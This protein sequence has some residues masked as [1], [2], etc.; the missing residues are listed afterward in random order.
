MRR[1]LLGVFFVLAVAVFLAAGA[2]NSSA[3]II[4]NGTLSTADGNLVS[5]DNL[6]VPSTVDWSIDRTDGTFTYEYTFN[7]DSSRAL[8]H[9]DIE[10]SSNFT[11]DDILPGTTSYESLGYDPHAGPDLY[12][13]KFNGS[14]TS[15]TATIVTHRMPMWGDIYLK[16]GNT[17]EG[18]TYELMNSGYF[19]A[20]PAGP[21]E[22][23]A[24]TGY[25]WLGVP[26]TKVV[27]VPP[28][29]FLMG[30]GLMGVFVMRR[31][32]NK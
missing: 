31:K 2:T 11:V 15:F 26:D 13:I 7:T 29:L 18:M 22:G 23:T 14:G 5:P 8:S 4:A 20:D 24:A 17:P 19:L 30:S 10:V 21:V 6:W 25:A 9:M 12:C 27:P 1:K 16:D 32:I 3:A 28:A